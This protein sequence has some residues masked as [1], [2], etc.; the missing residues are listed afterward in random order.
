VD[1]DPYQGVSAAAGWPPPSSMLSSDPDL[2]GPAYVVSRVAL[3]QVLPLVTTPPLL[4]LVLFR[5]GASG[6]PTS[7]LVNPGIL[8]LLAALE[9]VLAALCRARYGRPTLVGTTDWVAVRSIFGREWRQQ[10]F[11]AVSRF[12]RRIVSRPGR[13]LM[14]MVTMA[15][16]ED[17][18]VSLTLGVADPALAALLARLRSAGAVEVDRK[19]LA[20]MS[21]RH[22]VGLVAL[23]LGAV[24]L[25]VAFLALG[26]LRLLPPSMAGA[27]TWSGCRASLAVEDEHP[28]SGTPYLT[29]S[30]QAAGESWR[31]V[32]T[33]QENAS[34]FAQHTGDP[35]ARLAHLQNAGF[36]V[37]YHAYLQGADGAM[38][39]VATLRFSTPAGAQA[40]DTYVN[41]AVCEDDWQGRAGPRPTEVYLHRG[42]AA[43]VRWIAGDS[44]VEIGQTN[45]T[46]FC[47]PQ[48]VQAIAA[49]LPGYRVAAP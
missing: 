43:V 39:D 22:D 6:V 8:V 26:P 4:Y 37:A 35:K 46:P 7:R 23:I 2:P 14:A 20:P 9:V 24:A 44:I 38:V 49:A 16:R 45:S 47:T 5:L 11:A 25:P 34:A 3:R 15:D 18:R 21:R 32:T 12:S 1:I 17:R 36:L 13:G 27:F 29:A 48:Q 33:R 19:E 40:Y 30:L 42:R 28:Q 31:L 41:R 10:S